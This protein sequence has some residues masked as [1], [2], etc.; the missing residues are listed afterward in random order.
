[1]SWKHARQNEHVQYA[2]PR[3]QNLANVL[4]LRITLKTTSHAI[5]IVQSA[6]SE[7]KMLVKLILPPDSAALSASCFVKKLYSVS[8]DGAQKH[9]T[10]LVYSVQ[11]DGSDQCACA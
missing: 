2:P 1:M 8:V 10:E 6:P 9:H 11:H 5:V 7:L 4:K 3:F